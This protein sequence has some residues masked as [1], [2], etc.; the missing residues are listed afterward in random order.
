M[1]AGGPGDLADG[2]DLADEGV[3]LAVGAP[4]G[5]GGQPLPRATDRA[6][7]MAP[8]GRPRGVWQATMV[9]GQVISDPMP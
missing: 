7:T 8:T 9:S 6:P 3:A 4:V 5:A 2:V 1:A